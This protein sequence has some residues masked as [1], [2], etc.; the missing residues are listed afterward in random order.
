MF[1][2]LKWNN[3]EKSVWSGDEINGANPMFDMNSLQLS[4]IQI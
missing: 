4:T 3:C 2:C 1:V